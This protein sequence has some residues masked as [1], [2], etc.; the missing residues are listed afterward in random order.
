MKNKYSL[1]LS[2]LTTLYFFV[3]LYR[4]VSTYFANKNDILGFL[5]DYELFSKWFLFICAIVIA[6]L[7]IAT[8]VADSGIMKKSLLGL[9]SV[10]GFYYFVYAFSDISVWGIVSLLYIIVEIGFA[11]LAIKAKPVSQ[12]NY[13]VVNNSSAPVIET[14][15]PQEQTASEVVES[16][17]ETVELKVNSGQTKEN[18]TTNNKYSLVLGYLTIIF[19]FITLA[20]LSRA[21]SEV[22][23]GNHDNFFGLGDFLNDA[24]RFANGIYITFLWFLL[25]YTVFLLVLAF[26]AYSYDRKDLKI[27]LLALLSLTGVYYLSSA[28]SDK[29]IIEVLLFLYVGAEIV[30]ASL[31]LKT[32]KNRQ[33]N[34]GSSHNYFTNTNEA[35]NYGAQTALD[36]LAASSEKTELN[37]NTNKAHVNDEKNRADGK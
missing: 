37:D 23:V 19:V 12:H 31:A 17:Y 20:R 24:D 21:Y 11:G 34:Y 5:N 30:L 27:I 28:L 35:S 3:A 18:A 13:N 29:D 22:D 1:V 2:I 14:L 33:D 7:A 32:P 25:L 4:L 6:A 9:L 15:Q 36:V 16:N 10:F 26:L 8:F